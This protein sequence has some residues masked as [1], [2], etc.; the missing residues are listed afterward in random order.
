MKLK[1]SNKE[2]Y[3]RYVLA[4]EK[5]EASKSSGLKNK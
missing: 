4:N 3:F 2:N 5:E 1:K